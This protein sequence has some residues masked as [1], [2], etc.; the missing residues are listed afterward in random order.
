MIVKHCVY[1]KL[2]VHSTVG[3]RTLKIRTVTIIKNNDRNIEVDACKDKNETVSIK[4]KK[5]KKFWLKWISNQ[6]CIAA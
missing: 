5:R 4:R 6:D 2:Q 3:N 1:S